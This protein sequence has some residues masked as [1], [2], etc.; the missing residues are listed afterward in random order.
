M[1]DLLSRVRGGDVVVADGAM[2]TLLMER[3]LAPGQCPESVALSRPE[4]LVE[5]AELYAEAGAELIQTDTFGGSPLKLAMYGL[6]SRTEEINRAAVQ[7][8]RKGAADRGY[9]A[10][11]C[12][13]SGRLLTPYGD[14]EPQV[15]EESFAR[16]VRALVEAGIDILCVETMTDLREA[17]IAVKAAKSVSRNLPVA[18]SMTFDRTPRGF[19]TIMGAGIAEAARVLEEAGA[20]VVGSN[21]GNGI[22]NMLLVAEELR[23]HTRLPI[24][25]RSNAGRPEMEGGAVVYREGPDFF[26]EKA[27]GLVAHGVAIIGGCCGTTPAHVQALRREIDRGMGRTAMRNP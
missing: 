3:V 12:G 19:F 9:V 6:D 27:V 8:A 15:V 23:K 22:E 1:K 21:C 16:Q 10:A 17:V 7:A 13:P 4:V 11:S 24:L 18:A 26:A 25:I 14:T 2:G 20:D 5:I